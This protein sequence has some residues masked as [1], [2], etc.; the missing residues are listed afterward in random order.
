M[1]LDGNAHIKKKRRAVLVLA[2][3]FVV[4]IF[5]YLN[6]MYMVNINRDV[7]VNIQQGTSTTAI[8]ELLHEQGLIETP[9]IFKAYARLQND[10]L[11]SGSYL[12]EAGRYGVSDV[13][14]RIANADYGDVYTRITFPEGSTINEMVMILEASDLEFN[15]IE[16][17]RLTQG[18]EGYLF[19]ETYFLLPT[20]TEQEVYEKQRELFDDQY[21]ELTR[22]FPTS[23]SQSDIVNMAAIIEKEATGSLEEM[24]IVSGIL[25]K[26]MREG[27]PLQVDAPFL[28]VL[29]KTSAQLT[30]SDLR[31][32][33][34]YNTYTRQG[35]PAGPIANPGKV[36]LEAALDPVESPYYF[37]LHGNDGVIRY[38]VTH[39]DHINNRNRY[40][41]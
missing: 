15:A 6:H 18:K 32:D 8:A 38:G 21:K 30:L 40:L 4:S 16:Y 22:E 12:F 35:L 37:Y 19:P 13:Y 23:R 20:D 26:R 29:G 1:N 2:T 24:K 36:A 41:R 31:A 27:I 28:Y 7:L 33:G 17:R 39:D 11:K 10:T 14:T 25:W 5:V 3:L 9:Y 34:P